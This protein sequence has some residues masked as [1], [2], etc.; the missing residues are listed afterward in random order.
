[1]TL[2]S[3]SRTPS[4]EDLL[5]NIFISISVCNIDLLLHRLGYISLICLQVFEMEYDKLICISQQKKMKAEMH[6]ENQI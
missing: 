4:K 3:N 5:L 1:V 2:H 6:V